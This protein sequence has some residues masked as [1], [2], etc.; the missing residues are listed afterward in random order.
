[1]DV[2]SV[3]QQA[4]ERARWNECHGDGKAQRFPDYTWTNP[5]A[6]IRWSIKI[7]RSYDGRH[8][9]AQLFL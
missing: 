9:V 8:A 2:A 3:T 5:D 7:A 6:V 4:V 1:M